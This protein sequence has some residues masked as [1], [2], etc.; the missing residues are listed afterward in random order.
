MNVIETQEQ[1][2]ISK[3]YE[4]FEPPREIPERLK[5]KPDYIQ[6]EYL[7]KVH[8]RPAIEDKHQML[9]LN[10]R[11]PQLYKTFNNA[12]SSF[13]RKWKSYQQTGAGEDTGI[14]A[15]ELWNDLDMPEDE[16]LNEFK[17]AMLN[18]AEMF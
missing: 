6:K 10:T 13:T 14:T 18:E 17:Q 3:I 16:F 8:I 4:A 5:D 2:I 11:D 9:V 7:G 15:W 12:A 1:S